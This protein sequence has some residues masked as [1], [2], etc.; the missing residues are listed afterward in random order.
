VGNVGLLASYIFVSIPWTLLCVCAHVMNFFAPYSRDPCSQE[1]LYK[2][3][4]WN[5]CPYSKDVHPYS[6][7]SLF[8]CLVRTLGTFVCACATPPYNTL[9]LALISLLREI[10]TLSLLVSP[11]YS[12]LRHYTTQKFKPMSL[13]NYTILITYTSYVFLIW[14]SNYFYSNTCLL[15]TNHICLMSYFYLLMFSLLSLFD[16]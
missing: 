9:S 3:M 7:I 8:F 15:N 2:S 6:Y 4:S 10:D 5:L 14:D 13:I 11:L 1:S 12:I 16:A